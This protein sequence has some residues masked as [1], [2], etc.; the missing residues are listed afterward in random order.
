MG[1]K[2]AMH[3]E[4]RECRS[5]MGNEALMARLLGSNYGFSG[6][7]K[8]VEDCEKN[9]VIFVKKKV[10]SSLSEVTRNKFKVK[11]ICMEVFMVFN[12]KINCEVEV[13]SW[14]IQLLVFLGQVGQ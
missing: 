6:R 5:V 14:Y 10:Q 4:V 11:K 7:E 2:T 12:L 1:N 9:C 8:C 13:I 3:F